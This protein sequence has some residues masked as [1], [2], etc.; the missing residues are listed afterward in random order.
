MLGHRIHMVMGDGQ[1]LPPLAMVQPGTIAFEL[2]PPF[3]DAIAID[4]IYGH[5]TSPASQVRL[6]PD[7]RKLASHFGALKRQLIE[8]NEFVRLFAEMVS[9]ATGLMPFVFK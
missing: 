8:Q 7:P 3:D 2:R 1:K 6:R 5:G 4:L 9:P